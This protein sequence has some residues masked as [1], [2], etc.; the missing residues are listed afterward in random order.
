MEIKMAP[1]ILAADIVNL[2]RDVQMVEE[3]GAEYLHIDIMDGHFVPNLSFGPHLV[4]RLRKTS[5]MFFDVHLMISEPEKYIDIFAKNGADLIT[6][7]YEAAENPEAVLKLAEQIHAHGIKAG[8]SIKP[9][10]SAEVL[11]GLLSA[12]ELVLIMSVEPG[13]GGQSYIDDVNEKIS[14]LALMAK[15]ENPN[16]EIE[17]D[18][19]ITADNI[20][21]PTAAGANVLVAGSSVFGAEDPKAAVALLRANANEAV[22]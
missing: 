3:A 2:G 13:F 9:K 12:F 7:H 21:V 19:G 10:T 20:H 6:F 15:E 14:R 17:V 8:I 4:K 18:G 16:I 1:S 11:K 5:K 22:K